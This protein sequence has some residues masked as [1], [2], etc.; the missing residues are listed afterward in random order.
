MTAEPTA[1]GEA[2]RV[3]LVTG[4][5]GQL[6][7]ALVDSAPQGWRVAALRREEFDLTNA[8]QMQAVLERERPNV[9]LNAAAYVL[10]DR[11]ESEPELAY[12]VN[13]RGPG[14]LAVLAGKA[15]ARVI[16]VSTD[17][18]F[19]GNGGRPWRPDDRPSPVN[20]YGR[21]KLE[22]ER[23]V[24]AAS[25]GAG[26]VVRTSWV[27]SAVGR[28]FPHI[29]LDLIRRHDEVRV[30]DDQFGSPTW[31]GS[32]AGALWAAAARP[33]LRGVLHWTDAGVASRY[34]FAVA[35][36]EDALELGVLARP[37]RLIPVPAAEFP[38][39]ARRPAFGVLDTHE[40]A[41]ALGLEPRHWR[42]NLRRMLRT[43]GA[44]APANA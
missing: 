24:L 1:S 16:H 10:V 28:N 39:P 29:M 22:G 32:V 44:R 38:Q 40:T 12:A 21:T 34:D 3:A 43:L 14:T 2:R 41:R 13:A 19:D 26:L 4:A 11:A 17:C 25:G 37:A 18:V 31:V 36:Q 27:H 35:V 8:A 23:A 20:T 5:R 42:E 9:V 7:R 33:A 6:G 15:G 30:V